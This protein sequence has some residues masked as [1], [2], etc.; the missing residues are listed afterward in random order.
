MRHQL[1]SLS[2]AIRWTQE[3]WDQQR[4]APTRL[5]DSETDDGHGLGGRKF[6]A[7]FLRLLSER[8]DA[9]AAIP[10]TVSCHH[11]MLGFGLRVHECPE[12]AGVGLKEARTELYRYPMTLA[13]AKLQNSLPLRRSYPHPYIVVVT[14]AQHGWEPRA[15]VQTLGLGWDMGEA[16]MLHALRGLHSRYTEGPVDTRVSWVDRSESQRNAELGVAASA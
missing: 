1:A 12:C 3:R 4:T 9:T 2:E 6:S 7:P 5:H 15:T 13:L 16:L 11:P 10:R 8:L 14:L